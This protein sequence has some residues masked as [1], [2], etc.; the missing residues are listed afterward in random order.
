MDLHRRQ[1]SGHGFVTDQDRDHRQND[2]TRKTGEIAELSGPKGKVRI[3]GMPAGVCVSKSRE[4][5]GACMGAHVQTI[6]HQ[7]NRS[8][9]EPTDNFGAHHKAA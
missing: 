6:R 1:N 8:K 5:Q 7:C 4:Q 2:R 3:L 9:Q